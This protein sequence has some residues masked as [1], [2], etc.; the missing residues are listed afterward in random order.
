[1]WSVPPGRLPCPWWGPFAANPSGLATTSARLAGRSLCSP[2]TYLG[3]DC[4]RVGSYL[5]TRAGTGDQRVP[6]SG[7]EPAPEPAPAPATK[8]GLAFGHEPSGLVAGGACR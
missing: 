6:A 4:C 8:P 1:C 3:V 7:P 2:R 5:R